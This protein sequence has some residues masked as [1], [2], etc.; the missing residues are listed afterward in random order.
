MTSPSG[1]LAPSSSSLKA[2]TASHRSRSLKIPRRARITMGTEV[3]I[4]PA[5]ETAAQYQFPSVPWAKVEATKTTPGMIRGN[6]F[7]ISPR[8]SV[9]LSRASLIRMRAEHE[10]EGPESSCLGNSP[11]VPDRGS[12]VGS[13]GSASCRRTR[14]REN[15]ETPRKI[16]ESQRSSRKGTREAKALMPSSPF[17]SSDHRGGM[18][19]VVKVQRRQDSPGEWGGGVGVS[20]GMES[21]RS[22]PAE[23]RPA[24]LEGSDGAPIREVTEPPTLPQPPRQLRSQ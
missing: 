21:V 18:C 7:P 14:I 23:S 8:A 22:D 10:A 6:A 1:F 2:S 15:P 3:K 20:M 19:R 12:V 4:A 16:A 11:S 9:V 5:R 17:P 24:R 13:P